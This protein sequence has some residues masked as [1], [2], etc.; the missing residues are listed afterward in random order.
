MLPDII[1]LDAALR[2]LGANHELLGTLIQ[3]FFEDA[4][5]LLAKIRQGLAQNDAG[6]IRLASH[7][8]SGLSS[9]FGAELAVAAARRVEELAETNDGNL[10]PPAVA[11]LEHE[12]SLV[13]A[14]L[15]QH[16]V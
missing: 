1:D 9:N 8:L 12:I 11:A 10:L 15:K 14:A 5:D 16:D 4:P 3:F 13:T 7:R 6:A 2:R